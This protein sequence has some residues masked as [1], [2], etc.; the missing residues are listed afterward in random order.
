MNKKR[1]SV[2]IPTHNRAELLKET[3]KSVLDQTYQNFELL[4]IDN[5]ST[6][7]TKEVVESFKDKRI[8]YFW[9]E[10]SG[11]PSSP[12][13][14]GLKIAKGDYIA[15]LDS[16]DLWDKKKLEKQIEILNENEDLIVWNE[17]AIINQEGHSIGKNFTE[18]EGASKKN[19]S[20]HIFKQLITGN[21]ILLSSIIFK[22]DNLRNLKF[23]E[24]MN[25]NEDYL[26]MINLA[27]HYKFYFINEPLVRYRVHYTNILKRN[28]K[29]TIESEIIIKS[30]LL[31]KYKKILPKHIKRY[32]ILFIITIC[33]REHENKRARPYIYEGFRIDP[34]NLL[35]FWYLAKS[36]INNNLLLRIKNI[37]IVML[38]FINKRSFQ[39]KFL[40]V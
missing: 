15:F 34:F 22:K 33:F 38:S 7:N 1:V 30:Y 6:D 8:K 19:K 37:L 2:I 11:G 4:I 23:N 12:R 17:G 29:E 14:R 3:I 10:N 35:N 28:V 40:N 9:Q 25:I 13:N 16:D 20:G 39:S 18:V 36:L 5:G 31:N 32:L 26:F 24:R 27:R 21:F